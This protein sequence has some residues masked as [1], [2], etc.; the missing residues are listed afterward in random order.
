MGSVVIAVEVDPDLDGEPHDDSAS[1]EIDDGALDAWR[2]A[3][4]LFDRR[5]IPATWLVAGRLFA[6][7]HSD[8]LDTQKDAD[9]VDATDHA[10][11]RDVNRPPGRQLPPGE[12]S[13]VD[14]RQGS[15]HTGA[16][17]N[18]REETKAPPFVHPEPEDPAWSPHG[19]T[20]DQVRSAR[21]VPDLIAGIQ[22][23]RVGHEVGCLPFSGTDLDAMSQDDAAASVRTT[24]D[25]AARLG[26][27]T[28]WLRSVAFP[29]GDVGHR[30]VLAAYGFE[31]Y[32]KASKSTTGRSSFLAL[33][34]MAVRN[35]T[36]SSPPL[37]EPE[38]DDHGLLAV[39]IS[40]S[41]FPLS[42]RAKSIAR[43]GRSDL[44]EDL[45]KRGVDRAANSD[46]VFHLSI[47]LSDLQTQ[48]DFDRLSAILE[49]VVER[50]REHTLDVETLGML[51]RRLGEHAPLP[52]MPVE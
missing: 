45:V 10:S 12:E 15:E 36:K 30:D 41:L 35:V 49:H 34:G 37:V 51:A 16:P 47:R 40:M 7:V 17:E 18:G 3:S 13:Q 28:D 39:P 4:Y 31:C 9:D 5:E 38:T 43:T 21:S 22:Q 8:P 50:R 42:G 6:T 11:D 24:F 27:E 14:D 20:G 1:S 25:A 26:V 46:G 23:S 48:A 29:D 44:V 2:R 33:L 52:T 19:P 32:P